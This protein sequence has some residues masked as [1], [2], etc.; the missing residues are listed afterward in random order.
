MQRFTIERRNPLS[1]DLWRK[2]S[3]EWLPRICFMV[4]YFVSIGSFSSDGGLLQPTGGVKTTPQKTRFRDEN[5]YK[6]LQEIHIQVKSEYVGT[7]TT[8]ELTTRMRRTN[9]HE[10][11]NC[12]LVSAFLF[13]RL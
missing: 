8:I 1:T 6:E 9:T 10:Y 3:D 11:T 5:N 13:V 7:L 2:T 12:R 4:L